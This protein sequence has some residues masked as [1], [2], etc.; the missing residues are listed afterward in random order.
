MDEFGADCTQLECEPAL[1]WYGRWAALAGRDAAMVTPDAVVSYGALLRQVTE[2]QTRLAR[3][4]FRQ[5]DRFLH[6]GEPG[7]IAWFVTLLAGLDLH[8]QVILPDQDW[9]RDQIPMHTAA[10]LRNRGGEPADRQGGIWL[11]TSGTTAQPK[12]R[13][14]SLAA[15]RAEV[16]RVAARVP[17][18]LAQRKPASLCLLPLSHGFGLINALFLI[19]ALGGLVIVDQIDQSARIANALARHPVEVLYSWPGHLE[20]LANRN[21][22]KSSEV[23]LRWCVSSSLRLTADIRSRFEQAASCWVRQ[24]YG[25]T[26]IGPISNDSDEPPCRKLDCMGRPL[27]GV[28]VRVLDGSGRVLRALQT[29]EI[30]V[31]VKQLILPAREQTTDGYFRTGDRGYLDDA[32]RIHVLERITPFTDERRV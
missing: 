13:F 25:L 21:L 14:R 26:E 27:D 17:P 28:D 3:L 2:E 11:F 29:G 23:S 5:G 8:L 32:G 12:P 4:G 18:D 20:R 1:D 10:L 16:A 22:W 31:R 7:S 15:I 30:A 19:H 24:Q 6:D 9:P